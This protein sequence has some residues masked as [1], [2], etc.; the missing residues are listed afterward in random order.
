M[1]DKNEWAILNYNEKDVNLKIISIEGKNM[2]DEEYNSLLKNK[3]AYEK[4]MIKGEFLFNAI[5]VKTKQSK[6]SSS[7]NLC[8]IC[9]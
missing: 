5:N 1:K 2:S 9:Y 8:T 4:D 6:L 3:E 7:S